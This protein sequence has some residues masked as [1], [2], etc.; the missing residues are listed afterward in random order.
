MFEMRIF[1]IPIVKH[2]SNSVYTNSCFG[3][4]NDYW[5]GRNGLKNIVERI[6]QQDQCFRPNNYQLEDEMFGI[7]ITIEKREKEMLSKLDKRFW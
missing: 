2:F 3:M 7:L 1:W 5:N 4:R 6:Q